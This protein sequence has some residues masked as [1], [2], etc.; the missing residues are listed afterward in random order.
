MVY[1]FYV[2]V[3]TFLTTDTTG[4]TKIKLCNVMNC[5]QPEMLIQLVIVITIC[6]SLTFNVFQYLLCN[7]E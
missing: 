6:G 7:E 1:L 4:A 3:S 2:R 5:F